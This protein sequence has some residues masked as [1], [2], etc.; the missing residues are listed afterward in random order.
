M[1]Q[2]TYEGKQGWLDE[3]KKEFFPK[4]SIREST[5]EGKKGLYHPESEKFF[6]LE[7]P[8]KFIPKTTE[9]LYPTTTPEKFMIGMGKGFVDIGRGVGE[10]IG[11]VTPEE[12]AESRKTDEPLMSTTAGKIGHFTGSILP[13]M[14]I[15]GGAPASLLGRIGVGAATGAG[16]GF[17][18]PTTKEESVP[19]NVA[20]G[21]TLGGVLPLGLAGA[22]K[23]VNAIKEPVKGTIS[24]LSRK[25]GI[26]TTLGEV[27]QN[28]IVKKFESWLEEIP[29]IGL[30]KFREKQQVKAESAAKDFIGQFIH[31]PSAPNIMTSNRIYADSLFNDLKSILPGIGNQKI[32]P[33]E[34]K[35]VASVLLER[36]P[37][38]FKK[39]Q[40][41]KM[42]GLLN[43]IVHGVKDIVKTTPASK[44]LNQSGQP[45][46]PATTTITPKSLTFDEAWTLRKGLG[47]MIGQARKKLASGEVN[48]T[49]LGQLKGLFKAVSNDMESWSEKIGRPDIKDAFSVANEAYKQFVVRYDK[50]QRVYDKAIVKVGDQEFISPQRLA[51]SLKRDII[52]KDKYVKKFTTQQIQEMAGLENIMRIVHRA[53]QFKENPP[54]GL[55]WGLP[56]FGGGTVGGAAA[57]GSTLAGVGTV[58]GIVSMTG[59]TRFLTGTEVGKRLVLSASKIE[60]ANPAFKG[61]VDEVYRQIPR[62]VGMVGAQAGSSSVLPPGIEKI[63]EK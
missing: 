10:R 42:E 28:P 7:Q 9:E 53:G 32:L 25:F 22:S 26:P 51:G 61:I 57:L 27:T 37:D 60:P 24:D 5:Y 45:A 6:S 50:I 1:K 23:V 46:I 62:M 59:V 13:W 30:R 31:D 40:D 56:I 33:S 63:K 20:T 48:E 49:Q 52:D 8:N 11:L 2:V 15:P 21:A 14:A 19:L 35:Q 54:T 41:T 39:F 58:G 3:G 4:E 38:I 12:I 29:L 44:I 55:R 43:D 17:I 47:D 16:M 36:Y 34:S 18:Q